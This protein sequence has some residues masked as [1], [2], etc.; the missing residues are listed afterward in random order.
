MKKKTILIG[1]LVLTLGISACGNQVVEPVSDS[2]ENVVENTTVNETN[3]EDVNDEGKGTETD[4]TIDEEY[5]VS[6][7]DQYEIGEVITVGEIVK[8]DGNQVHIISGDLIE[9]FTY[10]QSNA[11]SFYLNQTVQLIK[12]EE[13]D[14]L[15]VFIQDDFS[16]KYTN[17]GH[18][19]SVIKGEVLEVRDDFIVI[20]SRDEEKRIMTYEEQLLEEG[21]N[22]IAVCFEFD[23]EASLVYFLNE[24]TKLDVKVIGMSRSDKGDML[25]ELE[26]AEEGLYVISA[27]RCM[28]EVNLSEIEIGTEL[29]IYNDGIKES[30]PMQVETVLVKENI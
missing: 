10:D 2:N 24:D 7:T 27:S 23:E 5:Y 20:D 12:G 25:L 26:D 15:E 4:E 6:S 9:V 30:W 22:I 21:S 19:L 8:F 18:I 17:M 11:D 16:V 28:L 1:I 14:I 13:E 3:E 29:T